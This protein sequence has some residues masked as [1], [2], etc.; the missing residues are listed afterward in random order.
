MKLS[1]IFGCNILDCTLQETHLGNTLMND[2][3]TG[4]F[5]VLKLGANAISWTGAVTKVVIQPNWRY[6]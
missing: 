2:Y 1:D 3:M 4:D 5:L 6:L